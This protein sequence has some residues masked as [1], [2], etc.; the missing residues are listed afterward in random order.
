MNSKHCPNGVRVSSVAVHFWLICGVGLCWSLARSQPA[1]QGL[2]R[3]P[4][5]RPASA[6]WI[7]ADKFKAFDLNP[8]A[9][10]KLLDTAPHEKNFAPGRSPAQIT[11]PMP[12][13][14]FAR[15]RFVESPVM[16]PELA[17]KFPEIKTYAGQ[18]IDDPQ[19]TVRFDVTPAG[20]HAQIFSPNGAVYIDPA[21]RGENGLHT[22]YFKRDH[23]R[24]GDDFRCLFAEV[25]TV[26]GRGA[27]QPTGFAAALP[28][29]LARSGGNLRTYRLACAA[30]GEYTTFH[31]GTVSAGL[32]A[33]VT[34][35]N[36]VT[37]V[38][39]A[40]LAI[41]LVLVADNDLIIYTS[42]G[43][44]PYNNTSGST[45]LNQNQTTLDSVIGSANYDIGHVFST[46]GGGIAGLG[47]VC[48]G[49]SKARGVTGNTQQNHRRIRRGP[50][51]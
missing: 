12:D 6:A 27:G 51:G 3:L 18:G 31:G 1:W 9:L 19:A 50:V 4:E 39:E 34:S 38:Y 5:D 49:G 45:M 25:A 43:S 16:A 24:Q 41:R 29:E 2:D 28:A 23:R 22:S 26:A 20:F 33:V 21:F 36:R 48:V 13:G 7:R 32:A 47:V 40:E 35:V 42:A 44:D 46:G 30:D 15:F 14:N 37:G 17:A 8:V 11:L 10:H